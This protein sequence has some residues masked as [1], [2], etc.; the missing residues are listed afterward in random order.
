MS[1]PVMAQ[2]VCGW[3]LREL[4]PGTQPATTGDL[5]GVC[6]AIRGGRAERGGVMTEAHEAL[7]GA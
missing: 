2:R 7:K 6:R 1:A 4:A 3:C 5:S